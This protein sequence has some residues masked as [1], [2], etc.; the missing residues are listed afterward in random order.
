MAR[1]VE[2]EQPSKQKRPQTIAHLVGGAMSGMTS[3]IMLQP[4]DLIKTRLQ[5][6]THDA[7]LLNTKKHLR[8]RQY[9]IEPYN[10][11]YIFD[12]HN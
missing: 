8:K 4:L 5:Q 9:V 1:S 11:K 10:E 7:S 3:C 2:H 12:M 6:S